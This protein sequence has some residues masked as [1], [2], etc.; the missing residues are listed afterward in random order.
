LEKLFESIAQCN[1]VLKKQKNDKQNNFIVEAKLEVP[2]NDL[3]AS[4]QAESF[5]I[6]TEKVCKDL[7][8]QVKKHKEKLYQKPLKPVDAYISEKGY[9]EELE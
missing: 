2:G 5:E 3:Y 8:S 9:D 1:I 4:D 6:A 7:E